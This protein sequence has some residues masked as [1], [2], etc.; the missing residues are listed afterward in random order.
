MCI[1][2]RWSGCDSDDDMLIFKDHD[3]LYD[4][5]VSIIDN[6]T[7]LLVKGSRSTRM[8]KIADKLKK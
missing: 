7:I 3:A 4:H 6:E 5:L 2:D 1:R 8:D